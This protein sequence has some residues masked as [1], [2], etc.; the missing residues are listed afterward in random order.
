MIVLAVVLV[1]VGFLTSCD[2]INDFIEKHT[3][4][5]TPLQIYNSNLEKTLLV[6]PNE[7]LYVEVRNL[8]PST[9]YTI[10]V[11]DPAGKK[12]SEI[13]TH[14]DTEGFIRPSPIWYNIGFRRDAEGRVYLQEAALDVKGFEIQ[15]FD[16]LVDGE[17]NFKQ[18][19]FFVTT[20]Q[21]F[22]RK[23]PIISTGKMHV[24]NGDDGEVF[25]ME[26]AFYSETQDPALLDPDTPFANKVFLNVRDMSHMQDAQ[27]DDR[28]V[29]IWMLPF[30][31]VN[32]TDGDE[33]S[34][35]AWFYQDVKI[36]DLIMDENEGF[37]IEWPKEKPL[38]DDPDDLGDLDD[39]EK[40]DEI[41]EWAEEKAFS[42]F[43][44]MMDEGI[45]GFYNVKKKGFESFFLDSIDGN[46]VAG[47]VVRETVNVVDAE[48]INMNLASGGRFS[49][50]YDSNVNRYTYDYDY[51]DVFESHGLN[52]MYSRFSGEFWGYGIK[53]IWN[54]YQSSST[55][56]NLGAEMP[57][58]FWG[59]SVDVYI[60]KSTQSLLEGAEIDQDKVIT[61]S[62]VPV[63][64][65]C[66]NGWWMQTIWRAPMEAGNYMI[67][68]DMD[69]DGKISDGDL[70]D[71]VK[72]DGTEHPDNIGFRIVD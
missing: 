8:K 69:S 68:V 61:R 54:P 20:T 32:Y 39:A 5:I 1:T 34:E 35:K 28:L 4:P 53:V 64:Y 48:V 51:R 26:N 9:E 62:R 66:G 45:S 21:N 67:I 3:R 72:R 46:G 63:Q 43:L 44:D 27:G 25:S 38:L 56:N 17:T 16:D 22:D 37:L 14:T 15:V 42:V 36:K 71:N 13:I 40:Q 6:V 7:T 52:T 12:I 55:W 31:G 59:S 2:L 57:S 49:W 30:T 18:P 33:I 29:R 41:P 70:V 50:I 11:L 19:F 58:D 24:F 65:G 23:K 60:V 47:F 10:R